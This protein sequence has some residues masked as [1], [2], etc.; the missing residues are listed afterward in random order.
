MSPQSTTTLLKNVGYQ[1]PANFRAI[2]Q[3][4][5]QIVGKELFFVEQP[6]NETEDRENRGDETPVG[7]ERQGHSNKIQRRARIH[8]IAHDRVGAGGDDLL[9][10]GDLDGRRAERI[11]LEYPYTIHIA[12]MI[13]TLPTIDSHDGTLDQPKR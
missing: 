4:A 11:F 10:L 3:I 1:M 7:A 13:K 5:G 12:T 8:R 2:V 6:P 9:V